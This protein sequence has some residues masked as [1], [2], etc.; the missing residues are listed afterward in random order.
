VPAG[1]R[2]AGG[3]VWSSIGVAPNGDVYATTGNGPKRNQFLQNSDSV[4]KLSPVRLRLLGSFKVPRRQATADGDF[5]GSPVFF[6]NYVGACNKN[7]VFYALSQA[8]MKLVWRERIADAA[9]AE[10]AC[11]AAPPFNGTDLFLAGGKITISGT[12]YGGSVQERAASTGK[13]VWATGLTG[14]V[15][16]SPTLDGGGVLTVGTFAGPGAGVFLVQAS[17]GTVIKQLTTGSTFAQSV[18]AR[19][20][21]FTANTNGVAAWG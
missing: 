5:G 6:G 15:L 9:G 19:G 2:D 3:S 1:S 17:N 8:T 12:T 7:G 11:L 10:A 13:V 20:L 18:F 14:G 4:L 16:G 21:L